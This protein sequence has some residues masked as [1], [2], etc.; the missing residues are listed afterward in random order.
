MKYKS[1]LIVSNREIVEENLPFSG[2]NNL[3]IKKVIIEGD[4]YILYE[5]LSIDEAKLNTLAE[6]RGEVMSDYQKYLETNFVKELRENSEINVNTTILNNLEKR[7][8]E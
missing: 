7:Y 4:N 1:P 3:G 8:D 6:S 2:D 5:V